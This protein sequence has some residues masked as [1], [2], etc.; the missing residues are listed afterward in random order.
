MPL[1]G[2]VDRLLERHRRAEF[3]RPLEGLVAQRDAYPSDRLVVRGELEWMVGLAAKLPAQRAARTPEPRRRR[4][5]SLPLELGRVKLERVE[6]ARHEPNAREELGRDGEQRMGAFEV[7][8][9]RRNLCE[10][11]ERSGL[12]LDVL[13]L[14]EVDVRL[15]E[16]CLGL[17]ELF[18]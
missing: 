6:K 12:T 17:P 18:L 1:E 7:A 2:E 13:R 3:P 15:L 9:L 11:H 5:L 16:K 14:A 4:G 10:T 8:S